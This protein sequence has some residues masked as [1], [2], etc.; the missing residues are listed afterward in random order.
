V[1]SSSEARG[2]KLLRYRGVFTVPFP[3]RLVFEC[4]NVPEQ[5]YAWDPAIARIERLKVR[6]PPSPAAV[7][8]ALGLMGGADDSAGGGAPAHCTCAGS[9]DAVNADAAALLQQPL[10]DCAWSSIDLFRAVTKPVLAV[11]AREFLDAVALVTAADG[12]IL[13]GGT[14]VESDAR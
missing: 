1:V 11:S 12:S 10:A 8:A 14:G 2:T 5:R 9:V 13:T 3:P 7:R 6:P 4:M